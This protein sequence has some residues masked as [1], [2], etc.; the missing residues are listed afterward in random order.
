[1]LA[2]SLKPMITNIKISKKGHTCSSVSYV[3]NLFKMSS[4]N[5]HK[6]CARYHDSS[7]SGYPDILFAMSLVAKMPKTEKRYTVFILIN[8]PSLITVPSHF[9]RGKRWSNGIKTF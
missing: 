4:D 8:V 7:S 5:L 9:L 3:W 6:V 1:M 2:P